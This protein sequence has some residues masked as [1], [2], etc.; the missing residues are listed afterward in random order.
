MAFTAV[1]IA[2]SDIQQIPTD[3]SR[4]IYLLPPSV[5]D[6]LPEKH[7]AQFV[8]EIVDQLVP[9]QKQH[10]FANISAG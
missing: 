8:V 1:W 2:P 7:L 9:V 6:W 4:Y 10:F 3:Q 5:Q